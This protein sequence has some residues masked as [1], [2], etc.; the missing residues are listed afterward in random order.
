M[1]RIASSEE[2]RSLISTGRVLTGDKKRKIRV[3]GEITDD[4]KRVAKLL[5][6]FN[7]HKAW[8]QCQGA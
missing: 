5:D 6:G 7:V 4:P 1:D 3:Y 2:N 8:T